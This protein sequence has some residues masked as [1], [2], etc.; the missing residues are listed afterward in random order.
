MDASEPRNLAPDLPARLKRPLRS[1]LA[2]SLE[3]VR[4]MTP[5]EAAWRVLRAL[6]AR[7][8]RSRTGGEVP[9]PDLALA[10][11]PWLHRDA[12]VNVAACI[13]AADRIAEGWLDVYAEGSDA[14]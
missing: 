13:A 9:P 10:G 5:A 14:Q 8:E 11:N 1:R 2:E 12:R 4:G 3:R 7:I 6:Q